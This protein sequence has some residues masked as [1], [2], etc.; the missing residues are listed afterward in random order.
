MTSPRSA[1]SGFQIH[2]PLPAGIW[3]PA[4]TAG[5]GGGVVVVVVDVGGAASLILPFCFWAGGLGW[6][7]GVT[8]PP[9]SGW[10]LAARASGAGVGAGR[11]GP[12]VPWAATAAVARTASTMAAAQPAAK[13]RVGT[14]LAWSP[15]PIGGDGRAS[16]SLVARA[17]A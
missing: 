7:R 5:A 6:V 17:A 16:A 10:G 15:P 8:T 4:A 1:S 11:P 12:W 2:M 9:G 14:C 13:T 3:G